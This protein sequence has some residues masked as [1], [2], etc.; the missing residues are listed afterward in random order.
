ML[1]LCDS[2]KLAIFTEYYFCDNITKK[3]LTNICELKN[4][5]KVR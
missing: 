3:I 4:N 1:K 5:L 2:Y